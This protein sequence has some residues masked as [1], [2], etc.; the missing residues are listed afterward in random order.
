MDQDLVQE[1]DIRDSKDMILW[2]SRTS[3]IAQGLDLEKDQLI[4]ILQ[5][6]KKIYTNDELQICIECHLTITHISRQ[7]RLCHHS[8]HLR[9]LK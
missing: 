1:M 6:L 8:V 4:E 9:A 7:S 2:P 5:Y 3:L